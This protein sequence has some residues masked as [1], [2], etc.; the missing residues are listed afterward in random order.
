MGQTVTNSRV[1]TNL[2]EGP[3]MRTLL[4]FAI[5]IVL[6][7]LIQQLYSLVDVMVIGQFVGN[8]GTVGVNTGGE[9]ADLLTP[10]AMGFSTAG[11]IYIAQ[12]TGAANEQGIKR[13]VGTLLSF[14]IVLSVALAVG[15]I[16]LCDPILTLLNCPKEAWSQA[17][18]YMIITAV[19]LPFIFGYNAVVGILRGMGESKRPLIFILVAATVNIV[20]DL[21][22]VV[23]I[24]MEAAGTAI[25]TAASQF[26]SFAAAFYFLWKKRDRFEFEFKLSYFRMDKKILW[27]L[28]KLGIPQVVRSLLVRFSMLWVNAT[29]NSYGMLVSTTNGLG[30]KLQKFLEV[31]IQGVDTASAAMVGQNLGARKTKR[32]GKVTLN[33]WAATLSCAVVISVL[34]LLIPEQIFG[35]FTKDPEVQAL[36]ATFL[37][38]MIVHF[39]ASATTGAFQAMVTGCGFVEL[40][41]LIGV[42]DGVVC[43]IGLSLLFVYVFD[44]GYLGLFWGVACSRILPAFI[45]IGYY[46]SGNW[47]TRKLL[48]D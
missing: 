13:T 11:Q 36:G 27:I 1:G 8:V 38:I 7:N 24:P 5:P 28:I 14:M 26:G 44:M 48:T 37:Q 18:S 46:L 16:L 33:T 10:V 42:L 41:F 3:I 39:F 12:L 23:V 40:G 43:K 4:T 17:R 19:G 21:L 2:T 31:F 25:A 32:A 45:C 6:T 22:L 20:L 35:I 47:K 9:V 15:T 34:C 30:N 29:A